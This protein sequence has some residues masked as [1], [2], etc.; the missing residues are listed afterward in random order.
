MTD[1]ETIIENEYQK[2]WSNPKKIHREDD[3]LILGWHFGYYEKG[4]RTYKKAI[5]NMNNYI[6]RLLE[7]KNHSNFKILDAGCGV[8]ATTTHLAKKHPNSNFYGITLTSN[9]IKFAEK[10]KRK[11]NLKN[12][13]YYQK[14]YNLTE[15]PNEYFDSIYALESASHATDET[16][17]LKEMNR[18]LKKNGKLVI[19]DVFTQYDLS[20]QFCKN[21]KQKI[22]GVKKFKNY[23]ETIDEFKGLLTKEGFG[24]III[25]NLIKSRNVKISHVYLCIFQNIFR[26]FRQ[27]TLEQ[28]GQK[29]QKPLF[30]KLR[31]FY[32][33]LFKYL[34]VILS[35]F[36]YFS[37]VAIKKNKKSK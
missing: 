7:I 8:G 10:L 1:Y 12:I 27:N 5:L 18:V 25:R 3:N 6:S 17:F 30:L 16:I 22:Y 36:S 24:N 32:F 37:I 29:T 28:I 26:N 11:N 19:I 14:S 35:R 4:F 21:I 20:D 33:L 31:F 9:E 13:A 34:L 15:F 23:A 2:R